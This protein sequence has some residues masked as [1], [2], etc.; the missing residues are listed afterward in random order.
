VSQEI[1]EVAGH[2]NRQG[3]ADEEHQ[4]EIYHQV[5]RHGSAWHLEAIEMIEL[6]DRHIIAR[7]AIEGTRT[8]GR[9]GVHRENQARRE[10][11]NH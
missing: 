4:K 2:E 7:N 6:F 11:Q 8:V 1:T 10:E 5:H 3:I 9:C